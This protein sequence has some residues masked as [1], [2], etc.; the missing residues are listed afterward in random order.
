MVRFLVLIVVVMAPGVGFAVA[1]DNSSTPPDRPALAPADRLSLT[2]I[3]SDWKAAQQAIDRGFQT[4]DRT[5]MM[6]MSPDRIDDA[7]L[8]YYATLLGLS[9]EQQHLLGTL[10]RSYLE[11]E[12]AV[13]QARYPA[14]LDRGYEVAAIYPKLRLDEG[15]RLAQDYADEALEVDAHLARVDQSLFDGLRPFLAP[16]QLPW[17]EVVRQ[18]R[19]QQ[20]SRI[21]TLA[22]AVTAIRCDLGRYLVECLLDH[23]ADLSLLSDD[24]TALLLEHEA[25]ESAILERIR[26]AERKHGPEYNILLGEGVPVETLGELRERR[27]GPVFDLQR[28]NMRTAERLAALLP[29]EIGEDLRTRFWHR[30]YRSV[31]PDQSEA[32]SLY[33]RVAGLDSL[34]DE[35]AA[36]LAALYEQYTTKRD[37]LHMAMVDESNSWS[38]RLFIVE[39]KSNAVGEYRAA[40]FDYN[41]KRFENAYGF[42]DAMQEIL[43]PDQVAAT[44]ERFEL[45][46]DRAESRYHEIDQYRDDPVPRWPRG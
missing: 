23:D 25:Q 42:V 34:T 41:D 39:G 45:W 20:R 27:W 18:D 8:V 43:T 32:D 9:A 26:R 29:T 30:Q 46:R 24:A 10:Y 40:M 11:D 37:A 22:T 5:G 1:G 3:R 13:R 28:L 44:R 38:Y 36:A 14:L 7:D 2:E 35:Q 31:F 15:T 33:D 4:G 6:A 16:S 12:R 21:Y 17:L 19:R